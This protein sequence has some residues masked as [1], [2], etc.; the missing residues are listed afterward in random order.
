MNYLNLFKAHLF[1]IKTSLYI[2]M[3]CNVLFN[4]L[5]VNDMINTC[6][7]IECIT[8]TFVLCKAM[9]A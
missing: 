5:I 2:I 6:I 7:Q 4:V 1:T 3:Y 8:C 9:L